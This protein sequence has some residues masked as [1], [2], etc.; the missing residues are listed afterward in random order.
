M[1]SRQDP[2]LAQTTIHPLAHLLRVGRVRRC[3]QQAL[4]LPK[5]AQPVVVGWG[6]LQQGAQRLRA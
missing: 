3:R 1:V 4:R 2:C 5:Q 6:Q